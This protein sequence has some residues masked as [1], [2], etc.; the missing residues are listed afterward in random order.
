VTLQV[1]VDLIS[2]ISVRYEEIRST[3]ANFQVA[4]FVRAGDGRCTDCQMMDIKS[5]AVTSRDI[6][7]TGLPDPIP[8]HASAYFTPDTK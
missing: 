7:E 8:I 1:P 2:F 5:V 4:P 6:G 3:V